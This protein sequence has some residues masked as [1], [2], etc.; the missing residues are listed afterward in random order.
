MLL[1]PGTWNGLAYSQPHTHIIQ[2]EK[3]YHEYWLPQRKRVKRLDIVFNLK[4]LAIQGNAIPALLRASLLSMILNNILLFA[5]SVSL[6]DYYLN[7]LA[8]VLLI[9]MWIHTLVTESLLGYQTS[10]LQTRLIFAYLLFILREVIF[11]FSFFWRYFDSA[12]LPT[13]EVGLQ[14]PPVGIVTLNIYKIPLLNTVILLR[15]G[16]S[17]TWAHDAIMLN[18]LNDAICRLATTIGFGWSFLLCQYHEYFEASFDISSGIYGRVFFVTTGFHG[19]HVFIGRIILLYCLGILIG[20]HYLFNNHL[21]FELSA[22]YWHFV[23][24]V[25][26]FL[27][28]FVYSWGQCGKTINNSCH[29]NRINIRLIQRIS[30]GEGSN[31]Y[32]PTLPA[33]GITY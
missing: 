12:L 10:T 31:R 33:I 32:Y 20:G 30:N 2:T 17:I 13:V 27:Y 15:R 9:L 18:H 11:F 23:D 29:H 1:D 28:T 24:V 8:V 5:R 21:S 4:L 14:W 22:W 3:H 16:L 6:S 26:L 25:W 7:L 19:L